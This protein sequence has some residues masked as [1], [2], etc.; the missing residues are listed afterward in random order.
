M[1]QRDAAVRQ[2]AAGPMP[3]ADVSVSRTGLAGR[4]RPGLS[5]KRTNA[6]SPDAA[7]GRGGVGVLGNMPRLNVALASHGG[8][9]EHRYSDQ[10]SGQEFRVD[11]RVSPLVWPSQR[12]LA[13]NG[14]AAYWRQNERNICSRQFNAV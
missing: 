11:H 8:G 7:I 14:D 4:I 5:G 10:S 6:R 1:V 2:G 3:D 13:L 9:C 12:Y